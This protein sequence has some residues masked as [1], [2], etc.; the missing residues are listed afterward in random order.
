MISISSLVFS[1]NNLFFTFLVIGYIFGVI[2]YDFIEFKYTDELM[3][4]FLALFAAIMIWERKNWKETLPIGTVICIFLFYTIY[5]FI[6]HSN[7]F[8]AIIKDLLIQIKP[9]I[10]FYCVYL[11]APQLTFAQKRFICILCLII[12]GAI[13]IVGLTDNIYPI[14][15][16]PSRLATATTATAF[17][18]LYCSTYT[19]SDILVFIT[20]LSIGLFST[21]SKFYGLWFIAIFLLIYNKSGGQLRFNWKSIGLFLCLS[22]LVVWFVRDKIVLYYIDGMMNSREIW[23]RP[24]MMLTSGHILY[25]YFPFGSGLASFGTYASGEYYSAIYEAYGI[26]KLWGISRNESFF[27]CDAFY[28]SLAQFGVIGVILYITFW[29]SILY[30]GYHY[31]STDNQKQWI[32]LLLSFLFFLIEGVADTTFTHNRGLF[33]LIITAITLNEMKYCHETTRGYI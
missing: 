19:W 16:H 24:A 17:L 10:G 4:L 9:F 20:L 5:S 8:K 13:T 29:V 33:I 6:I 2:F 1:K 25:D 32:M 11:I 12:G 27:I 21:R 23:S 14:F 31:I 30:K 22:L 7:V 3:A 15:G 26:D 18:F 28:P